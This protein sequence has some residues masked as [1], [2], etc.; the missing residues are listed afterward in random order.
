VS[1]FEKRGKGKLG[2]VKL[3]G[4][5]SIGKRAPNKTEH[6]SYGVGRIVAERPFCFKGTVGGKL[7]FFKVDRI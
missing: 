5:G 3:R 6:Y 2:L 4:A 7:H 1:I